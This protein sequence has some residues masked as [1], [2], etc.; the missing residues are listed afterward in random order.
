MKENRNGQRLHHQL[1]MEVTWNDFLNM[2]NSFPTLI[3]YKDKMKIFL[4]FVLKEKW[5]KWEE[6]IMTS[7]L[8]KCN[9]T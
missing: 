9:E 3:F 1:L 4:Y 5:R 6:N 8:L 7:K 2:R